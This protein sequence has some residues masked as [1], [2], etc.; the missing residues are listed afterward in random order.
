MN[1]DPLPFVYESTGDVTR[2]TDFRDLK[3]LDKGIESL[4]KAQQQLKVYRQAVLKWA[5]EGKFTNKKLLK[6]S[7]RKAGNGLRVENYL[8]SLQVVQEVGQ[9][10]IQLLVQFVSVLNLD[11][12]S[13]KLD[14]AIEKIQY[15][16]PPNNSEGLRI[17]IQEGY[18]LFSITGYWNVCNCTYI[19]KCF[20]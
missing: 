4:K 7:Y 2:F 19:G 9:N 15:V 11:F 13:L 6:V 1:N 14:L 10:T 3:P 5:F 17:K 18:F 16:K 12:D 20:C 8:T